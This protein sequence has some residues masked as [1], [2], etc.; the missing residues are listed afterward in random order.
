MIERFIILLSESFG[1]REPDLCPIFVPRL[2]GG[3]RLD[4][5]QRAFKKRRKWPRLLCQSVEQR[6]NNIR[7]GRHNGFTREILMSAAQVWEIC[8]GLVEEVDRNSQCKH[9]G[10]PLAET[11]A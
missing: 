2:V 5:K 1:T 11:I 4:W 9:I 7:F 6:P 8:A 10:Q 3:R